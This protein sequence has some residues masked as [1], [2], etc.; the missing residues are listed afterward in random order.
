MRLKND[1]A[2]TI[3]CFQPVTLEGPTFCLIISPLKVQGFCILASTHAFQWRKDIKVQGAKRGWSCDREFGFFLSLWGAE[4]NCLFNSGSF[5][6]GRDGFGLLS[7]L[8]EPRDHLHF[9]S[10]GSFH[11]CLRKSVSHVRTQRTPPFPSPSIALSTFIRTQVYCLWAV[12]AEG[13]I[14]SQLAQGHDMSFEGSVTRV[15]ASEW[16]LREAF[17]SQVTFVNT[18]P[19]PFE[20]KSKGMSDLEQRTDLNKE[21]N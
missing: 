20:K 16:R 1:K 3:C 11:W 17:I 9:L 6:F 13:E 10:L 18:F 2:D 12:I 19:S 7:D 8:V 15:C 4:S 21:G 5:L 14:M